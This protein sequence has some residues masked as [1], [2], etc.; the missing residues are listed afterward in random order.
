M[1]TKKSGSDKILKSLTD[2]CSITRIIKKESVFYSLAFL[3]QCVYI[4]FFPPFPLHVIFRNPI[5]LSLRPD[6]GVSLEAPF[7]RISDCVP[8]LK[9]PGDRCLIRAGNYHEDVNIQG[10]RGTQD[11]PI[12]IAAY[13][14]K[15]SEDC[16]I[17]QFSLQLTKVKHQR[18]AG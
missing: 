9:R 10:I 3:S 1:W 15:A 12:L 7:R 11:N 8:K 2:C 16:K 4:D 14:G 6:Y 18:N 13:K 5:T 17:I